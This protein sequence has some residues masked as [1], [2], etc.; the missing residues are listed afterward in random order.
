EKKELKKETLDLLINEELVTQEAQ[1]KKIVVTDT[2][3]DT[4]INKQQN[5]IS[6][7]QYQALLKKRN[8][9][10]ES[11][12]EMVR[13]KLVS[14]ALSDAVTKGISDPLAKKQAYDKYMQNVKAGSIIKVY[15]TFK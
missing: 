11:Y 5:N 4:Y 1:K 12:R 9:T 2:Q 14:K 8:Y 10:L 15:E 7:S 6:D 3:V 13:Y